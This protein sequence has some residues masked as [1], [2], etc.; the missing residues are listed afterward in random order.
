MLVQKALEN[1]MKG[2]TTFVIAHRLSTIGY[3][4]RIVVIVDGEIVEEGSHDELFARQGD[5][6]KLYQM[7]FAGGTRIE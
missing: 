3:A 5:Y 2:R 1:L 6:W 4:T 7:Q